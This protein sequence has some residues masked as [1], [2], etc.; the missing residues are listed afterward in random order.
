MDLEQYRIL[1]SAVCLPP[2]AFFKHHMTFNSLALPPLLSLLVNRKNANSIAKVRGFQPTPSS[3]PKLHLLT[4]TRV[5]Q[6]LT[7]LPSSS[8]SSD[9][10]KKA[11]T[12]SSP[13]MSRPTQGSMCTY[14]YGAITHYGRPF[15]TI[16]LTSHRPLA[17]SA[18][19]RHY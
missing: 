4:P 1:S 7:S 3:Q 11:P 19:A 9:S 13:S 5:L 16:L 17:C 14:A 2:A 10:R 12:S 18:F 6:P 15:Q 8:I